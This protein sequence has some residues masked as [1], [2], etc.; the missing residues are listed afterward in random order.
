M[1]YGSLSLLIACSAF[2]SALG[3]LESQTLELGTRVATLDQSV[4]IRARGLQPGRSITVTAV[5]RD[6]ASREWRSS[7]EFLTDTVGSIDLTRQAPLSGS[8]SGVMAMG[9]LQSMEATGADSGRVR[10]EAT[11]S[12]TVTTEIAIEVDGVVLV[13]DSLRRTF[14]SKGILVAPVRED[15]LVGIRFSPG[16]RPFRGHVLVLG[17][18]EGGVSSADV[19]AQLASH[20]FDALALAYFGV[21]ALPAQLV[22]IPLE[23]FG[24]ALRLLS[25]DSADPRAPIAILGTSKGAEAALLAA[26][27]YPAV[28]GVVAYAPSNVA[29]ACICDSASHS[30]WTWRGHPVPAVPP[31]MDPSYR[32]ATGSPMRPALNYK[33]RLRVNPVGEAVIPVETTGA[34]LLLIAGG[35]DGLWPSA[36]MAQAIRLRRSQTGVELL[37]YESAGHLIGKSFL[38]AG[39][40]LIGRGRI[41]TGGTAAANARAQADSWPRVLAFLSSLEPL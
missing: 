8:Y 4:P 35:D 13:R 7:A 28:R 36:D 17:G 41:E 20:G 40:T 10:F 1:T 6:R 39:S 38:P 3:Q 25:R 22:E 12:D 15:G 14:T 26:V 19:A 5:S 33:Y 27:R 34:K 11:W 24:R 21:E 23:Y 30:S 29:W 31:G 37:E 2:L 18:S 9:L 16:S 32:P